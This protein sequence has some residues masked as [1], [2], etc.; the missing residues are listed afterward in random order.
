MHSGGRGVPAG[1]RRGRSAVH[2]FTMGIK[3]S[4]ESPSAS[5]KDLLLAQIR[6]A[7]GKVVYTHK[8][9]EKQA[10]LCFRNH[11]L[12]RGG[13]VALTAVSSGTF[14]AALLNLVWDQQGAALVTSFIALLVT[15]L[16][17]GT[18]TFKYGE[19]AQRHR[20]VASRL[21][22]VRES[23]LSLITDLMSDAVGLDEARERRDELQET[24]REI[25]SDAPRTTGKAYSKAQ[26]GLKDNE[27]LTFSSD[28]VDRFLPANLRLRG[29]RS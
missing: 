5:R 1:V 9:H 25:Y 27:E 26:R 21:W 24:L 6:E 2:E 22:D 11:R 18:K 7:Y 4:T 10:D 14:L 19:E 3:M 13:L 12:Q 17:L 16:N 28:E 23:Y 20:D 15:A 8:T 29:G